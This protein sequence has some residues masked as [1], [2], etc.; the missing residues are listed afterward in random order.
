[1]TEWSIAL[2]CGESPRYCRDLQHSKVCANIRKRFRYNHL[3][4]LWKNGKMEHIW[5][6]IHF[7][8]ALMSEPELEV[9]MND[10]IELMQKSDCRKE[11]KKKQFLK[12]SN[13]YFSFNYWCKVNK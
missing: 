6:S 1:V 3:M 8:V 2:N 12:K 10:K 4:F 11:K 5:R 9:F 13:N 7:K